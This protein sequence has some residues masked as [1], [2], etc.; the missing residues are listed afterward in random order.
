VL[1]DRADMKY[2][3]HSIIERNATTLF[4]TELFRGEKGYIGFNGRMG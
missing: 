3:A 1:E 2:D 4:F